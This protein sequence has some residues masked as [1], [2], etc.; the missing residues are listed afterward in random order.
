V[1]WT[2]LG[3]GVRVRQSRAFAMNS[4][5]LL[6]REHAIAIDPGVLPSE[7]DDLAAAHR[8]A[9]ATRTSL[10]LTH[11]HWDHVL[12]RPW[13]PDAEVIAHDR[14]AAEIAADAERTLA[15]AERTAREH[16]EAWTRGFRA[17]RPAY[18]VSGLHYAQ[19]GPWHLVFRDAPGHSDS[20]LTLHLPDRRILFAAD[21]LSDIELPMLDR[22]PADYRRTLEP[23]LQ[24]VDSG[25]VE[26]LVPGHGSIATGADAVRR[27]LATD[28]A[29][30]DELVG[31]A[32]GANPAPA[33]ADARAALAGMA[34][35]HREN[36][37]HAR[38][39]ARAPTKPP[40]PRPKR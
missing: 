32:A 6:D 34:E 10:F 7:I 39:A 11:A 3:G 36:V 17:F 9:R 1:S 21:M 13:W 18:A 19:R 35:V 14:F 2:D 24:L 8:E 25:A 15:E 33:T 26:T 38:R 40:K 5:L 23:L 12:A 4:A 29:Y 22:D 27:R 28:L 30:L 16:D 31:A 37:E 20:Q